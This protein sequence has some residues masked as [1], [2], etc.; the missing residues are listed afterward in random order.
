MRVLRTF[1]CGQIGK[2]WVLRFDRGVECYTTKWYVA[3]V[4]MLG[5]PVVSRSTTIEGKT[6]EVLH[7]EPAVGSVS[8]MC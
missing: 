2:V 5:V 8:L 1:A 3:S 6:P 4:M 7:F